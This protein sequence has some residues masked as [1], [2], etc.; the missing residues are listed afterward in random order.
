MRGAYTISSVDVYVKRGYSGAYIL[1]RD[2]KAAHYV[3]RSDSDLCGGRCD[4]HSLCRNAHPECHRGD[5]P[6]GA[7]SEPLACSGAF[8]SC[9]GRSW[10]GDSESAISTP[11]SRRTAFN[12]GHRE[13]APPDLRPSV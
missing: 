10:T 13:V 5:G 12:G 1:S 2:G 11:L 6:Q 9:D 7:G 8:A 4:A 3:G